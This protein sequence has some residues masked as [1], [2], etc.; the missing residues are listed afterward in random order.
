MYA[1][2]ILG[3]PYVIIAGVLLSPLMAGRGNVGLRHLSLLVAISAHALLSAHGAF[4][5]DWLTRLQTNA[6]PVS[7]S[8][9]FVLRPS[10]F[11]VVFLALAAGRQRIL[12]AAV[13]SAAIILAVSIAQMHS[14][15]R[16]DLQTL[17]LALLS[18]AAVN[19]LLN[20][21][22]FWRPS[23]SAV[24]LR[25]A[26]VAVFVA[27]CAIVLQLPGR[28]QSRKDVTIWW[29]PEP[30]PEFAAIGDGYGW[31]NV[32]HFG[33][34]PHLLRRAGYRVDLRTD[35]E[36]IS[37]GIIVLPVPFRALR[38]AEVDAVRVAVLAGSRALLIAEHTNLDGVQDSFNSILR[39]TAIRV[40]FDT[41]N[42]LF[43]DSTMALSG[44]YMPRN[45]HLTHN[46]GASLSVL[47]PRAT[48]ILKGSWWHSDRGDPF[49]PE[50]GFLSDYRV[51][52]AD[53]IGNLVLAARAPLGRGE[54]TVWGDGSP[55]LNQN[56]AYNVQFILDLVHD[57]GGDI[58]LGWLAPLGG[59]LLA[60]LWAVSRRP[61]IVCFAVIVAIA[62]PLR[63]TA[64]PAV[65]PPAAVISDQENNG[66][67][68]DPFSAT[69]LTG[70]AVSLTRNGYVPYVGNWND[71][72]T[73]PK[74]L[75]VINPQRSITR[76]FVGR[77]RSLAES[78]T[79]VVIAGA[80]DNP[81]FRDLALHFGV[82]PVGPPIGSIEGEQFTTYSAWR[83]NKRDGVALS[84]GDV[85]IGSTI[86]IGRGR[87]TV[88]A[89]RG[90][91]W[92]KNLEAETHYD[93]RNL[94]F[95]R[96]LIP[97]P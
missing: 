92:S 5:D 87:V 71:L 24:N 30:T 13:N 96:T 37:S 3:L 72:S 74:L 80:G 6:W 55:F 33:E 82:E 23:D 28:A 14:A 64:G 10:T 83:V 42:A 75:F 67:D 73:P 19:E 84:A 59:V 76:R 86:S 25:L 69:G 53:R 65:P 46:R 94:Q 44:P 77:L 50:K 93:L 48:V 45:R 58:Q 34:L 20:G 56:L 8:P 1:G 17:G 26:A 66:F 27:C 47:S 29:P 70:L 12:T 9:G 32:G 81:S 97:T 11:A 89:D 60:V 61:E 21:W 57:V 40:N 41:T 2:L 31:Q 85:V 52:S 91:F 68:R 78:G 38:T 51:S 15:W 35:L 90:F 54:V 63:S 16:G 43:G 4:V 22:L 49:S 79:T 88:I 18:V 62:M 39:N 7:V 36:R 95:L